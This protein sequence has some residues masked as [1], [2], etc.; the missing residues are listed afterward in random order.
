MKSEKLRRIKIHT[1]IDYAL[2]ILLI[3]S[4]WIFNMRSEGM[5]SKIMI[6]IGLGM[7]LNNFATNHKFGLAKI[8]KIKTHYKVDLF[9]GWFL[10]VSPFLYGF[11]TSM[12]FPHLLFGILIFA[13]TLWIKIP[14]KIIS[15]QKFA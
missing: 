5:E 10:I 8:F 15:S 1:G 6:T 14:I 13:N 3:A 9:F 12:L 11:F 2:S 4:P 7:L